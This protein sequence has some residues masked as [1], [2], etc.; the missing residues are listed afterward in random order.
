MFAFERIT[1]TAKDPYPINRNAKLHK[2]VFK[3][4]FALRFAYLNPQINPTINKMK[5]KNVPEKNGNPN[6][7]TKATSKEDAKATD[8]GIIPSCTKARTTTEIKPVRIIPF[9]VVF[10]HRLKYI[11]KAIAGTA[12][13]PNK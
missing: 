12:S 6:E 13:S 11:T 10:S 2:A 5:K 7:L 3:I 1:I 4:G 8:P 9:K